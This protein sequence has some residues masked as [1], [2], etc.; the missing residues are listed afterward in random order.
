MTKHIVDLSKYNDNIDWD[1]AAP[2]LDLA[3]CRV[4][5]G[6]KKIDTL[7]NEHIQN[8]EKHRIPH[9]AYAYGCYVS[10][11]DA[12]VE[13]KDFLAR[14][15]PNAKFLV[16]DVEDDTLE[17]C[18]GTYLAEA[19]QAFINTCRDAG[20]KV[21]LYVSHHMYGSYGLQN[22]K[23]DFLWIPRYGGNK[24]EYAC[25]LWQYADNATGGYVEGIGNCDVNKLIGDKS[26]EWFIGNEQHQEESQ[27]NGE[28][29]LGYLTTTADVANIRKEPNT[30]AQ[31]KRQAVKGDGHTYYKWHWDGQHFW[32][33]V[34]K[35]DW[36]RDDTV[37]INKDG[38]SQGVVYVNASGVNVRY[39][40][41]TG[42]AVK[43]KIN[44]P[45]SLYVNFRHG[46]WL[47]VWHED[48]SNI[49][50]GWIYFADYVNWLR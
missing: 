1:I 27:R 13:A 43:A 47:C 40:A 42:D 17:S 36:L 25:D 46:D 48:G 2:Q 37:S 19:T 23:A 12:I 39:G 50:D 3:I 11:A 5:Y 49:N 44:E 21:G 14:V 7:Y 26:L 8:L 45:M 24:P 30:N 28:E 41:S 29:V 34:A 20:W 4:Q 32:F 10:I 31:I 15:N 33:E 9:A 16:L 35:D 22:I 38:K 18:G 6:S